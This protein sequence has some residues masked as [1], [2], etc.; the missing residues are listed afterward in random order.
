[1]SATLIIKEPQFVKS[2]F[3]LALSAVTLNINIPKQNKYST[4]WQIHPWIFSTYWWNF[5]WLSVSYGKALVWAPL[6][7]RFAFGTRLWLLVFD[8]KKCSAKK[9]KNNSKKML[10]LAILQWYKHFAIWHS[11]LWEG[12]RGKH[13]HEWKD[14][15]SRG[16]K[17]STSFECKN[18]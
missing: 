2:A 17:D 14:G 1:M 5:N 13:E 6:R 16:L 18:K 11:Y 10:P 4:C 9:Q 7:T 12:D 3:F 15:G 8:K